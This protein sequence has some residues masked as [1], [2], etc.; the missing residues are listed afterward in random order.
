MSQS[1]NH[2]M[3]RNGSHVMLSCFLVQHQHSAG[4]ESAENS[5][6]LI[7]SILH[8]IL[9]FLFTTSHFTINPVSLR[10]R[11]TLLH[12]AFRLFSALKSLLKLTPSSSQWTTLLSQCPRSRSILFPQRQTLPLLHHPH[13]LRQSVR[14][15][16]R[17][18]ISSHH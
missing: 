17:P 18:S 6:C 5:A 8:L 7:N 12:S 10:H 13:R 1:Q 4:M 16:S 11:I 14:I 3:G 9:S 2:D 15:Q